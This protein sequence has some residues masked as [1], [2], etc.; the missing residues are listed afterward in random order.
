MSVIDHKLDQLSQQQENIEKR[1]EDLSKRFGSIETW[2]RAAVIVAAVFGVAG[3]FGFHALRAT[4]SEVGELNLQIGRLGDDLDILVEE[5]KGQLA[6][7]ADELM[8]ALRKFYSEQV[9]AVVGEVNH[10]K[11][12]R[13]LILVSSCNSIGTNRVRT[14]EVSTGKDS[15][16]LTMETSASGGDRISV[17]TVVPP[18]WYYKIDVQLQTSEGCLGTGWRV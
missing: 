11:S 13:P 10:N 7:H 4:S 8:G 6:E 1:Y 5:R 2:L 14:I 17:T 15:H 9:R 3:A 18:G 16:A 12:D